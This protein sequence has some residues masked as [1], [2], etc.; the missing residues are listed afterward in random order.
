MKTK[1]QI[2]K[3]QAVLMSAV[4]ICFMSFI[5]AL[6]Q[7]NN[8]SVIVIKGKIVDQQT[9]KPIVYGNVYL[10]NTSIGTVSN[11]EGEFIIK[12]PKAMQNKLVNFSFMG[13]KGIAYSISDLKSTDNVIAL[14]PE[15]VNIKEVIVR[16]NDPVA[17]IKSAVKNV[18]INYGSSPYLC[19]AFYREAIQQNK[20]Y[21]GVAEAV[22]NV[23]KSRYS[24][25][26]ESDRI[27]VYKGRKSQ[28]VRKMDTL[29]FKLQGGTNVALLLDLAKNPESFMSDAYFENYEYQPVAITNIEGRETYVIE[30]NQRKDIQEPFYQ[31]R[32][33]IDVATLAIK[34]ADFWLSP[35]GIQYADKYLVKKKPADTNV[36]TVSGNYSVDY[37][38]VNGKWTLNHVRYEVKFKVD[39]KKQWFSKL[40]TSTVDMAIT[41]KDTLNVARFKYSESLKPN[42]VFVEHLSGSYDE[43][44][45]GSYNIIKPEEPIQ[46]AVERISKRMKKMH[47]I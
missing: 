37:R 39:K 2:N 14:V 22:L 30:F 20:Q 41:D 23:Y 7:D 28:D 31:G 27:K 11:S 24:S 10:T 26:L 34:K 32:L 16:T 5:P 12:V 3:L 6:A 44:F 38:D 15:T 40:Y 42:Q 35:N 36:K 13:Y 18:S 19:T 9:K 43:D 46:E 45:W 1:T 47:N 25:D 4:L 17:L 33:Y 8:E 21:V 29:I